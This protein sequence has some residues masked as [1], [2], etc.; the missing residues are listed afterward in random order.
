MSPFSIRTA[1]VEN[2]QG[3][4]ITTRILYSSQPYQV[5]ERLKTYLYILNIHFIGRSTSIMAPVLLLLRGFVIEGGIVS[6][7]LKKC[8]F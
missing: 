8:F 1:L 6:G 3:S 2:Y 4:K 7:V 5:T